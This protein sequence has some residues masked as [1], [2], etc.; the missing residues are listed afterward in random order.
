M[1][2]R[3][4]ALAAITAL[5]LTACSDSEEPLAPQADRAPA[6]TATPIAQLAIDGGY[7]ELVDALLYVDEEL[8]TGLVNLFMN[9]TNQYT[10]F[11]PTNAAF[12][13]LY[14]LLSAVL[15][16]P[17]DDIRDVPA[18]VVLSVL[19]YHV[20]EGR[21][22]AN[23]V[24]PANGEREIWTLVGESFKVRTNGTIADGLTGLRADAA[25]TRANLSARNGIVHEINQ[26][27]VPP[28]VVALLT[29]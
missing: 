4:F 27:I 14:T 23:S 20:V 29:N 13:N 18:P 1:K 19:Q 28:S 21:R 11:A 15:A 10:V 22:A 16:T 17:I 25:I 6:P 9:G 7:S 12:A 24:V 2:T 3:T 26:V 5:A 8:E